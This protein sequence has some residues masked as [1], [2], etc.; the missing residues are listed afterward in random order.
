MELHANMCLF[1]S[2][3]ARICSRYEPVTLHANERKQQQRNVHEVLTFLVVA[4]T[5]IP[6][7]VGKARSV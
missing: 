7:L 6:I 4:M 1:V 2:R 5:P 3:K